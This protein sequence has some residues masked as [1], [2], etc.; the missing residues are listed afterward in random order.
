FRS[1]AEE[2]GK[3]Q[4][5][6]GLQ[7]PT[8]YYAGLD[9][10]QKVAAK[11]IEAARADG[12]DAVWTGT[13]PTGKC[14]W[15]G[16]NPGNVTATTWKPFLLSSAGEFRPPVPPAC[17]SVQM[18]AE[19][20]DVKNFPRSPAAFASNQRA[21]YWQSPEGLQ[22]WHYM[23][24]NKWMF[25]SKLDQNPPRWARVYALMAASFFDSFIASQDGKF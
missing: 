10:G 2:A 9:L 3:S 16:S 19:A 6:A 4:L 1:M 23:Y 22:F 21:M 25:E 5:Y 11:V 13:V 20:A 8:D 15:I 17:D 24:A 12:S 18:V 14:M 7:F